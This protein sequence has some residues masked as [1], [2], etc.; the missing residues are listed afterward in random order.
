MRTLDELE[1]I[2][3]RQGDRLK[4]RPIDPDALVDTATILQMLSA[5]LA[6]TVETCPRDTFDARTVA[7]RAAL[8]AMG[9]CLH[10]ALEGSSL[11]MQCRRL[12]DAQR[13]CARAVQVLR[14]GQAPTYWK[15]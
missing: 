12:S 14:T 6:R 5:I 3:R 9:H 10:G 13:N 7:A 11:D 2:C 15:A 4:R 1:G 8:D